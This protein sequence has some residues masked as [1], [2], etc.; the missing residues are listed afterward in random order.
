MSSKRRLKGVTDPQADACYGWQYE[1]LDWNRKTSTL[2]ECRKIINKVLKA[3]GVPKLPV[4]SAPAT[5]RYSQYDLLKH[6]IELV[7]SHQ[8]IPVAL[9]EATHAI[10]SHAYPRAVD[11]GPTFVGVLLDLLEQFGVAPRAALQASAR[12]AGL[13]WRKW[14]KPRKS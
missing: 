12:K 14:K 5:Q 3:Y 13:R 7:R 9:H 10:V 8:N 11:H 1:W 2:A 6:R 4:S